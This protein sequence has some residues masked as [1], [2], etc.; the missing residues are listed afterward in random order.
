MTGVIGQGQSRRVVTL[1][2][3]STFSHSPVRRQ[4]APLSWQ[5]TRTRQLLYQL[6]REQSQ[7]PGTRVMG[8]LLRL[9]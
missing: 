7:A 8:A 6:L 2:G 4:G 5:K 9:Y 1:L 3:K